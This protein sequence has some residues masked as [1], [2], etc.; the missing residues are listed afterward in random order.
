MQFT[1]TLLIILLLTLFAQPNLLGQTVDRLFSRTEL[2]RDLNVLRS[3]YESNLANVYL[4][5]S[6]QRLDKVFDS[7]Y[8]N[9]EPMTEME[10]YR[11]ITPLSSLIKDGHSNIFPSKQ[12]TQEHNQKSKFFP[13]NIYWADNKMFI[14]QNL[15]ADTS[16]PIGTEI[17]SINEISAKEVMTYLLTRQ[18]RDGNNENYALWVLNNYFREYYSYHFGHPDTYLLTIKTA[19]N[20]EKQVNIEAL[21]KQTISSNKT[22]RYLQQQNEEAGYLS[23]DN[24]SN[25]A[26]FTIQTWDNKKL[27]KEIDFVFSQLQQKKIDHLILDLRDNQGGNFS[28]AIYLLSYLLN[29]PFQYFNEIQ[30]VVKVTDT[31]QILK[32]RKGKMLGTHQAKKNPYKGKLYV[33]INGGSFSNTGSFCS[34]LEF[35]KRAVFIGEETGGNKVVFSGVF[36]LKEETV[37]PNTKIICH[38]SNYRLTVTD[39]KE[40]NGHGVMPTYLVK[41]TIEDIIQNKDVVL[42][43]AFELVKQSNK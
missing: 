28:P 4:Y 35:Y 2:H 31:S 43:A 23:I 29:Q 1:R 40:N 41:P 26:I 33:L 19:N 5:S 17:L 22:T 8:V 39:I 24:T 18:V 42:K 12:T 6:K 25:T 27:K 14:T 38:N 11:Y 16:I 10:F 3:R 15:S 30:S 20:T 7:L 13:F 37:L 21:S 36:G 32:N 9:I 34:R